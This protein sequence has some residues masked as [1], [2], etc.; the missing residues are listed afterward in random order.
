MNNNLTLKQN[1]LKDSIA[2]LNKYLK[3]S[4]ITFESSKI[5]IELLN[6]FDLPKNSIGLKSTIDEIKYIDYEITPDFKYIIINKR[7][8]EIPD[9]YNKNMIKIR[10]NK[11]LEMI[12]R[13]IIYNTIQ[14]YKSRLK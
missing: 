4:N 11:T 5:K 14:D 7:I 12:F 13:Q 9:F 3:E 1:N 10:D 6:I 2:R 8:Y